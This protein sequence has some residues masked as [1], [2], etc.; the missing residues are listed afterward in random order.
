MLHHEYSTHTHCTAVNVFVTLFK[1]DYSLFFN[2]VIAYIRLPLI[3][4]SMILEPV[5]L[6]PVVRNSSCI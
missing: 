5:Q 2:K 3:V 4:T 1:R 6:T